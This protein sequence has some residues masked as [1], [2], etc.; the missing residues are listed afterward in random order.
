MSVRKMED[1]AEAAVLEHMGSSAD[2]TKEAKGETPTPA[3]DCEGAEGD[4]GPLGEG[5]AEGGDDD[6][7][8][9]RFAW[10]DNPAG[11]I[12]YVLT[13]PYKCLLTITVP[14]CDSEKWENW[15]M[16]TF[17][18]SIIWIG[19]LCWVMVHFGSITG[20]LLKIDPPVMGV[21]LLAAGTSVPDAIASVIVARNG[22][23]DMA[24]ANAVGS[25]VFDILLG[26][27]IPWL[28]VPLVQERKIQTLVDGSAAAQSE[29][30]WADTKVE[31]TTEAYVMR[32]TT[33]GLPVN[34][35]IL[36]GTLVL[37]FATIAINKFHM[38]VK[39]GKAFCAFYAIYIIYTM[40]AEYC[41][42]DIG[43]DKCK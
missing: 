19:V 33:D 36:F 32:V 8:E 35:A 12:W 22:E 15:Y 17:F 2:L 29:W 16:V 14:D 41:V 34:I 18:M 1:K 28:L 39:I 25:N 40:M 6:D 27:G 43:L 21:L 31:P 3:A 30:V 7:D 4:D 26:L 10:P 23:A 11:Q 24:I 42:I 13:F 20:C 38:N 5:A 9:D 37:Y